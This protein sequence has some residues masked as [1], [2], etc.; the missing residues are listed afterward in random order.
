MLFEVKYLDGSIDLVEA[1]EYDVV[2][3][4]LV[5]LS[6]VGPHGEERQQDIGAE[7]VDSVNGRPPQ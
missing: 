3:N 7:R 5:F 4:R 2:E 6:I 1:D